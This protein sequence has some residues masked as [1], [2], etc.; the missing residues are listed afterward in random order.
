[1]IESPATT[2]NRQSVLSSLE[3]T[4]VSHVVRS[5][6]KQQMAQDA[7]LPPPLGREMILGKQSQ[8]SGL[9]EQGVAD[10]FKRP[11]VQQKGIITRCPHTEE[12]HF[13]KGM[14]FRCYHR[15][16]RTKKAWA[17]EHTAQLLYS[18]GLCRTCYL[19]IKYR[20][21]KAERLAREAAEAK[22]RNEQ[23]LAKA[24]QSQQ[25]SMGPPSK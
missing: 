9:N 23:S 2:S 12:R 4:V 25:D 8:I 17:C 11:T 13:C 21:R 15:S 5:T 7:N 24:I 19:A 22:Q 10:L 18:K 14:C 6:E 20:S 3:P 1:M 16:G